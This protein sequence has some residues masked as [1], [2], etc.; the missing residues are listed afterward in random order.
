MMV[1]VV[2]KINKFSIVMSPCNGNYRWCAILDLN[3]SAIWIANLPKQL[4]IPICI[5][6]IHELKMKNQSDLQKYKNNPKKL[7]E[8]LA[9]E[10]GLKYMRN[11]I[12]L[13]HH[14]FEDKYLI[15]NYMRANF[16]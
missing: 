16:S 1:C 8:L 12:Q 2:N 5:E 9:E 3:H 4:V 6:K 10:A 15:E 7:H 14:L 13:P 11:Y